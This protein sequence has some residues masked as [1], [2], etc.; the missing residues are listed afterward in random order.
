MG[1]TS[2][3]RDKNAETNEVHFAKKLDNRYKIIAHGTVEGVFYAAVRDQTTSEVTAFIAL[4]RWTNDPDY[5]FSYK[6]LDENCGPGDHKAPKSVLNALTPTTNEYA[7]AW[8]AQCRAHHAQ[9]DFLRRY[10]KPGAQVRLTHTLTFTNGTRSDTFTY[11]R[12][13]RAPGFLVLGRNRCRVPN[14]RD[15]VAAL[16]TPDHQ[17]I[18]TPVGQQQTNQPAAMPTADAATP[19]AA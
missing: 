15:S 9:R 13:D 3:R 7:L 2:Y 19:S 5:N 10:L 18:L 14:W 1:W 17:E 16:I 8:R 12:R 4:T 11:A 6:D